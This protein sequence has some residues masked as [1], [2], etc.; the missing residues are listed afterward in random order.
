MFS[1]SEINV[2]IGEKSLYASSSRKKIQ[3][4][5]SKL[6]N[7]KKISSMGHKTDVIFTDDNFEVGCI[8]AGLIQKDSNTDDGI[9]KPPKLMK[10]MMCVMASTRPDIIRSLKTVRFTIMGKLFEYKKSGLSK[11]L[12]KFCYSQ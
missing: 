11:S 7:Q 12:N 6:R 4:E 10:G 5:C 8:E 1:G 3:Q 9:L 2:L